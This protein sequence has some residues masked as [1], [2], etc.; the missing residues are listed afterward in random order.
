MFKNVQPLQR[1]LQKYWENDLIN[2]VHSLTRISKWIWKP[3]DW[4]KKW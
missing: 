1:K 4:F 2:I 3:C